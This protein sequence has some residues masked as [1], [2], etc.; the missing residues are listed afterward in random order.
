MR[1][2]DC[3]KIV[4]D[5]TARGCA[6]LR[7]ANDGSR[8]PGPKAKGGR[9]IAQVGPARPPKLIRSNPHTRT[10]SRFSTRIRHVI[11]SRCDGLCAVLSVV[12]LAVWGTST[13]SQEI[14]FSPDED[15]V[16]IDAGLIAQAK[17]SIDFAS[18]AL[19]EG[20]ILRALNDADRRGV[21]VRIMLDPR[22]HHDFAQFGDL[23]DNVRFKRFAPLMPV[24]AYEVDDQLLRT[25]SANF[26][27]GGVRRQDNDLIVFHDAR[28]AAQFEAHFQRMWNAAQ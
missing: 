28:A 22:E 3:G 26:S 20:V 2:G 14:H 23:S 21:T 8:E 24:R 27:S 10:G 13:S 4:L 12:L 16:A 11:Q 15:L 6:R 19:T 5:W 18:Y 7:R 1:R 9:Q 25:G 17:R